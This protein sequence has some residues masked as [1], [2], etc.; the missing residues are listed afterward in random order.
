MRRELKFFDILCI[1][2]NAI[3]GSG[4]FLIPGRLVAGV[5]PASVLLFVVCGLL[6]I[7]I[8][9]CFAE[10]GSKFEKNGGP[11]NYVRTAFGNK[12]GFATGWIDVVTA[13]FAYAA[14]ARG[15]SMYAATFI[16]GLDQGIYPHLIAG[17][18]IIFLALINIRG[19]RMGANTINL[20][21]VGKIFPLFFLVAIGIFFFKPHNFVPFAPHGFTPSLGLLLAVIFTYQG[22]EVIPVPAGETKYPQK[23]VPRAIIASIV[24]SIFIYVLIQAVIIGSGAPVAGSERP[25]ADTLIHLIGPF[26][27]VLISI[28]ALIS[29]LGYCSG[30]ALGTPRY[31][32]VLCEDGFLPV[33]GARTHSKYGTPYVAIIFFS[34]VTF[35]LTLFLDFNKLVDISATAVVMQYILT[36]ASI[37]KLRK[38]IPATE[39]TYTMPFG[40]FFP[41]L[42]ALASLL[43]IVQIQW[44]QLKWSLATI[45][46]G[47]LVASFYRIIKRR[48]FSGKDFICDIPSSKI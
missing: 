4:I 35:V 34:I 32:T 21:T 16:H 42:G 6:L 38:K 29:M 23:I 14:A 20:F 47:L 24:I 1:G 17:M 13:F 22:F 3:V 33:A 15:I 48:R 8:G 9:L 12:I 7:P 28:G 41:L 25:L 26:G 11:Y 36:C 37:P 19:I 31:L 27:I 18:L 5:G 45:L 43:F 30:L 40:I 10:A 2:V 39:N 46:I 44:A